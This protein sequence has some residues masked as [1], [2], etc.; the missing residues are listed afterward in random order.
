MAMEVGKSKEVERGNVK[1]NREGAVVAGELRGENA[2]VM[3]KG[4]MGGGVT[5]RKGV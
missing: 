1:N 4:I 5:V 3:I 2:R